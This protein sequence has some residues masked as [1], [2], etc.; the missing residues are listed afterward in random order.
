MLAH[1]T[2][3]A[4]SPRGFDTAGGGVVFVA[5]GETPSS[6]WPSIL[7]IEAWAAAG[8]I[9]IEPL[10]EKDAKAMRK[11]LDARG[12][13]EAKC[14]PRRWRSCRRARA[15]RILR[16]HERE[17]VPREGAMRVTSTLEYRH[18]PSSDLASRGHL[19]PFAGEGVAH[20]AC[21][22]AHSFG[23]HRPFPGFRRRIPSTP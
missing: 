18:S 20:E 19:L 12:E 7:R 10:P 23:P 9:A 1:V 11:R 14:R 15:E 3:L 17:K 21:L 6:M 5:P 16:P 13:A 8:E 2:N 4:A 22:A